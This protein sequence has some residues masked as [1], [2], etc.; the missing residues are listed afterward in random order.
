MKQIVS[1]LKLDIHSEALD[2]NAIVSF[3]IIF[4]LNLLY[5]FSIG[6]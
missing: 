2:R 5:E 1:L 6:L 4:R 3:Y